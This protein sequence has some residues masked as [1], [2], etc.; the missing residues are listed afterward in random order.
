METQ[1]TTGLTLKDIAIL[2]DGAGNISDET[3]ERL[4]PYVR[5]DE[6]LKEPLA[7]LRQ[8]AA[9]AGTPLLADGLHA[10]EI[11]SRLRSRIWA[12]PSDVLDPRLDVPFDEL[13]SMTAAMAER[14]G[15]KEKT[16]LQQM[17]GRHEIGRALIDR[18]LEVDEDVA[19]AAVTHLVG[20]CR[21]RR[22]SVG[23]GRRSRGIAEG[24][25]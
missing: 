17:K 4:A 22:K 16:E 10:F 14:A 2:A 20:L 24:G 3:A 15:D 1:T 25:A 12:R 8:M 7:E 13:I 18:L 19:E 21:L 5:G 9:D 23:G 6:D 11:L